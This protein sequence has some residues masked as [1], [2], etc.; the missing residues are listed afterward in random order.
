MPLPLDLVPTSAIPGGGAVAQKNIEEGS[1]A[2]GESE[3]AMVV[4]AQDPPAC[5]ASEP[6][7]ESSP[8]VC[9]TKDI[10]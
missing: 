4:P 3:T 5:V 10:L 6:F 1:L 9:T 7:R 2:V 8:A